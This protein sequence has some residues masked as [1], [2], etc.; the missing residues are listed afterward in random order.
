MIFK[1]FNSDSDKVLSKI[2][3]LGK[4]FEQIGT[5]IRQRKIEIDNLMGAM[6]KKDTK[7]EVGGFLSYIFG[8]ESIKEKP[9][10]LSKFIE[11][12]EIKASNLLKS[13]QEIEIAIPIMKCSS[14]WKLTLLYAN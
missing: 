3:I 12:D 10:D 1:T 11:L 4:S 13:L 8:N 14:I 5:S 7:A 6:S 2:G 9:I